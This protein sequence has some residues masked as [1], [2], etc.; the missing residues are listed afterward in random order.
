M[1]ALFCGFSSQITSCQI[2]VDKL[3]LPRNPKHTHLTCV[4][5]ISQSGYVSIVERVRKHG[6]AF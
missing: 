4:P 5:R 1:F 3:Y 2:L 6:A